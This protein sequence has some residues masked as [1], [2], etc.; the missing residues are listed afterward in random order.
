MSTPPRP[1]AETVDALVEKHLPLARRLAASRNARTPGSVRQDELESA[2][3]DGLWEAARRFE[4]GRGVPFELYA[5]RIIRVR[6][7]D[8]L[9]AGD[10]LSRLKRTRAKRLTELKRSL[11]HEIGRAPT[12]DEL[13]ERTGLSL[14]ELDALD[15]DQAYELS[16]E[17]VVWDHDSRTMTLGDTL[18]CRKAT[19]DEGDFRELTRGLAER[20]QAILWLY[21]W[22]NFSMAEIAQQLG[23]SE[24]RIS[25]QWAQIRERLRERLGRKS[26]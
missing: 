13:A 10:P 17:H 19:D 15:E 4:A 20:S 8:Q 14:Y 6:I 16:L 21:F 7:L 5:S 11:A 18:A 24:S 1:T 25:Q 23:V 26:A 2:A 12:P 22:E 3:L 9:R